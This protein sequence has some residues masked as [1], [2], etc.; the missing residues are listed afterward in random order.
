MK[1]HNFFIN[2]NFMCKDMK[3]F[4]SKIP[5]AHSESNSFVAWRTLARF[6]RPPGTATSESAA[7]AFVAESLVRSPSVWSSSKFW[8]PITGQRFLISS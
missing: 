2:G 7:L 1:F 4:S 5:A 3:D 8:R 6:R